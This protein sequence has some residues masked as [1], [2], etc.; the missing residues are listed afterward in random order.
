MAYKLVHQVRA[1]VL[2]FPTAESA[3]TYA[4]RHGGGSER[5]DVIPAGAQPNRSAP[6]PNPPG[7]DR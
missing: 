2:P 3:R 7:G 5:W 6:A 1:Q 4:A